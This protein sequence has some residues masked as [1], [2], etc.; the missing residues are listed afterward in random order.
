MRN[1]T[2][3][4]RTPAAASAATN[5]AVALTE[6]EGKLRDVRE[7]HA[8]VLAERIVAEGRG[9]HLHAPVIG[10]A[11][12]TNAAALTMLNGSAS[13]LVPTP[14][15]RGGYMQLLERQAVLDRAIEIGSQL[16]E[17][18]RIRIRGELALERADEHRAL[19]N[20]KA[21]AL[22]GLERIDQAIDALCKGSALSNYPLP[23]GRLN[24]T[25]SAIYTFLAAGVRF[26]WLKQ[27]QLDSEYERARATNP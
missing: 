10:P 6:L 21:Q 22:I 2:A 8:S 16:H 11:E 12:A 24:N 5:F 23:L 25:A 13:G 26:G 14:K 17:Q 7:Q 9:A 18:L 1:R 15:K 27:A 4:A 20:Q 3:P 19:M